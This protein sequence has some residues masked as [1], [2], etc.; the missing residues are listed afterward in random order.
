VPTRAA[1][2]DFNASL[3]A[4]APMVAVS[5]N[6]PFL[7]GHTLWDETRI[8]LFEQSVDVGERYPPRVSFGAATCSESLLELFEENYRDHDPAARPVQ[9]PP[10]RFATCAFT[11]APCGAGTGR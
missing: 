11:T 5:A 2:R 8:P 6:S 3:V 7:F 1:V 10:E 4:S 9:T